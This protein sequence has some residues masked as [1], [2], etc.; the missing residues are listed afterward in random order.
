MKFFANAL[1][2][3]LITFCACVVMTTAA[4]MIPGEWTRDNVMDS[5][6]LLEEE[7][8]RPK[9]WN[10][11]FIRK[12]NFTDATMYNISVTAAE[13]YSLPNSML[14]PR[15]C[16][17]EGEMSPA[18][19]GI[20]GMNGNLKP[21]NRWNY[22]RYWHGYLLPLRVSS[23]FFPLSTLRIINAVALWLLL[24]TATYMIYR[25][26]GLAV[27]IC[28]VAANMAVCF[29]S[30][31]MS[32][33]FSTCFYIMLAGVILILSSRKLR[34]SD[35][36]YL[37]F[38]ATGGLTS[39]FDFLTTPVI[40]L[41]MPMCLWIIKE[42]DSDNIRHTLG[43]SLS[44]GIGYAVIWGSKWVLASLLTQENFVADAFNSISIHTTHRMADVAAIVMRSHILTA[45]TLTAVIVVFLLFALRY[46]QSYIGNLFLPIIALMP[47]AWYAVLWNHSCVH[48]WFTWRSL[49]VTA[50]CCLLMMCHVTVKS[51]NKHVR[52]R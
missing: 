2:T 44:W 15:Y 39:Y 28:F 16:D 14:N 40:T 35:R 46:R 26:I 50:F 13:G 6:V 48:L 24:L 47:I 17:N 1:L 32:L 25:K 11:E 33:Q 8:M 41:C 30:V 3:L 12:D 19:A 29:P 21:E 4:Y 23:I 9:V 42:H 38:I 20:E 31:T 18:L 5:M 22:G 37:F 7:G 36:I 45:V 51:R 27:A 52:L 49:V 10:S 34:S 43:M